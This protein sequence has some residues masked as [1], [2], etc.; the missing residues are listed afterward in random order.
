MLLRE[1]IR[2]KL[3]CRSVDCILVVL[4]DGGEIDKRYI[5]A[6]SIDSDRDARTIL[7]VHFPFLVKINPTVTTL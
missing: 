4:F 2:V 1:M 3:L 6:C 7:K 5:F